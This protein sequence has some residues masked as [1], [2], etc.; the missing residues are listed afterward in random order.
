MNTVVVVDVVMT[1]PSGS[2]YMGGRCPKETRNSTR[3]M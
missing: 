2:A 1:S 3:F